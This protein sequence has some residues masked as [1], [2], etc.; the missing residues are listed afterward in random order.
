[1]GILKKFIWIIIVLVIIVAAVYIVATI[2]SGKVDMV[3]VEGGTFGMGSNEDD[4]TK[5]VH[6]VTVSDFY[7][8]KYEVTQKQYKKV[9]S[10]NPSSFKRLLK[11]LPVDGVSWYN[12]VEFC[13]KLS[14]M[15][16]LDK[17]YSGSGDN[18]K[19]NFGANGYRLP[20]EAEWEYAA[21]GGN[22]SR[23]YKYCR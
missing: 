13:N 12:G 20:T 8:G 10:K 3:F 17:C 2:T 22:K 6:R 5:P 15:E 19:C 7:I 21:K 1:L 11:N 14:E 4:I 23:G 9:M 18:I 16:G